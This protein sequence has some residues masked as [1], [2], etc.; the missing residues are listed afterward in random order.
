MKQFALA[1]LCLFA[2]NV[3]S[4]KVEPIE[5]LT[6][7]VLS[8]VRNAFVSYKNVVTQY[9]S[10]DDRRVLERNAFSI[11]RDIHLEGIHADLKRLIRMHVNSSEPVKFNRI[12]E[13]S[14]SAQVPEAMWD[15][16]QHSRIQPENWELQRAY[17]DLQEAVRTAV[18]HQGVK[19]YKIEFEA[20]NDQLGAG[21][22]FALVVVNSGDWEMIVEEPSLLM[23]SYD[24]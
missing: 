10:D 23:L 18:S 24:Y 4:A 6:D 17:T 21:D 19:L 5:T 14:R 22:Y 16:Y 7:W 8:P 12:E 2:V 20:L 9:R 13:I 15:F 11:Q 1:L 3:A